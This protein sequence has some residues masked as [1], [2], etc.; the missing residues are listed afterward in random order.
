MKFTRENR[1]VSL[2]L[3]PSQF[4]LRSAVWRKQLRLYSLFFLNSG[5]FIRHVPTFLFFFSEFYSNHIIQFNLTRRLNVRL[6]VYNCILTAAV[7]PGHIKINT[8]SETWSQEAAF[9]VHAVATSANRIGIRKKT[10]NNFIPMKNNNPVASVSACYA[11]LISKLHETIKKK[12]P[13]GYR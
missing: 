13:K 1:L 8:Q 11:N 9:C 4:N 12:V 5:Y 2:N 10:S 3:L 7:D 6:L